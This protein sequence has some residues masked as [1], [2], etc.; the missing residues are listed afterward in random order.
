MLF[1]KIDDSAIFVGRSDPDEFLGTHSL[2]PFNLDNHEWLT[3]EHYFQAM[4]FESTSPEYFEKIRR[5]AT[6]KLARKLGRS[7]KIK[8]R[9]DW[10]TVKRVVMTRALYTKCRTHS[11]V[12]AMLIESGDKQ[13]LDNSQYD[14]YWGCGRD[15]RAQNIYGKVLM[16]VR[17]KLQ[18]EALVSSS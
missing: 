14:Y 10:A 11:E 6:A 3:V 12:A 5:I 17:K 15:R 7:N 4:K 2:H 1:P 8:L 18:N 9:E 16:D 13:I